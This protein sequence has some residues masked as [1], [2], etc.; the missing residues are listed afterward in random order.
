MPQSL[1]SKYSAVAFYA[2]FNYANMK[3]CV[4]QRTLIESQFMRNI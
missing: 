4:I 2:N 1:L 3:Q